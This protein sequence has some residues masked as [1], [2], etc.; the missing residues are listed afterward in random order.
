MNG[1]WRL[2][3]LLYTD[4]LALWGQ[5]EEDLRA[6]VGW[7]VK[8]CRKKGRKV[9]A[10]KSKAMVLNGE[11]GLECGVHVDGIHL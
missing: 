11:K 4:D 8:V 6:M 2:P 10:G 1:E 3:D 5:S 7:F 9:N